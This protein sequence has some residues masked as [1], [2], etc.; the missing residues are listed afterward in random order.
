MRARE[1]LAYFE[2]RTVQIIFYRKLFCERAHITKSA[3]EMG[4]NRFIRPFVVFK[5]LSIFIVCGGGFAHSEVCVRPA[6]LRYGFACSEVCAH[7]EWI[8]ILSLDS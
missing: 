6:S 1:Q 5:I 3:D 4:R 8:K 2:M 7:S